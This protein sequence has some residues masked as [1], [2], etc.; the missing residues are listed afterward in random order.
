MSR[1]IPTKKK[2]LIGSR[3]REVGKGDKVGKGGR[4]RGHARFRIRILHVPFVSPAF[5]TL[6]GVAA[7]TTLA[8]ARYWADMSSGV[9][10]SFC[11]MASGSERGVRKGDRH[12]CLVPKLRLGTHSSK[13]CFPS[14]INP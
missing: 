8:A 1:N 12:L 13:L 7:L 9:G 2:A 6:A 3:Q 14:A 10:S 5:L 4:Q 11:S